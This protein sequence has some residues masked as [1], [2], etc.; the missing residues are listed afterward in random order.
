MLRIHFT[1]GDLARTRVATAPHPLWE[2]AASLHRFQT[3]E[4][5]WAYAHWYR[6]A[7]V[8]LREAGLDRVLRGMLLPLF[9]R[10]S[11]FPDFLTPT[12]GAEGLDAGLHAVLAAPRRQVT[13]ETTRLARTIPSPRW[14]SRLNERDMRG[15]LVQALR[16]YHRTVIAPHE[17]HIGERLQAERIRH[18][19]SLLDLGVEGMLG[20]LAPTIRWRHPVLEIPTYPERRDIHLDGRGLLLIPSYFCWQDPITL[21]DPR[22]R[23]VILYPL[24]HAP[25]ASAPAA[26]RQPLH[27]LLGRTRAAVLQATVTGASTTEAARRAGVSTATATHHTAALREAGLINSDRHANIV[28]HTLTPLGAALLAGA[29]PDRPGPRQPPAP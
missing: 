5:R 28:L 29:R 3:R 24:H 10:T 4:G 11:Y 20:D 27:A 7:R 22:L 2:I 1:A 6:T 14:V 17:D 21:A 13:L 9:P 15:R 16:D 8:R 26:G 19:R 23:P 25:A 18:A 12:E